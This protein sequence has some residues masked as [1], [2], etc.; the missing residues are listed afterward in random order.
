MN[1]IAFKPEINVAFSFSMGHSSRE[2]VSNEKRCGMIKLT[3]DEMAIKKA[4]LANARAA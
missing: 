2:A 3:F 1:R 4:A